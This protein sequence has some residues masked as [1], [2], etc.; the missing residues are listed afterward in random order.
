MC[1]KQGEGYYEGYAY[2]CDCSKDVGVVGC[3]CKARV[4][5]RCTCRDCVNIKKGIRTECKGF[6]DSEV[7]IQRMYSRVIDIRIYCSYDGEG[8]G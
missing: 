1:V 4:E 2:S 6:V 7:Y 8:E 3:M 5:V